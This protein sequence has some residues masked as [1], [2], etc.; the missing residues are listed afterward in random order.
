MSQQDALQTLSAQFVEIQ[1][2]DY[3]HLV[4]R[5]ASGERHSFFLADELPYAAWADL[6][7][8]PGMQGK[9]LELQWRHVRKYL[10]ASGSMEAIDEVVAIRYP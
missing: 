7:T 9:R 6:D 10:D 1:M 2:G 8:L 3:A 4:V 5:D